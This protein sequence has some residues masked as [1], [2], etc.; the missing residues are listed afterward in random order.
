M[1]VLDPVGVSFKS[2]TFTKKM[3]DLYSTEQIIDGKKCIKMFPFEEDYMGARMYT[4]LWNYRVNL[5]KFLDAYKTF[6]DKNNLSD[7]DITRI[8]CYS[9]AMYKQNHS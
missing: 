9:D 5:Q 1:L 6:R 8:A 7:E 2:L 4:A 3:K